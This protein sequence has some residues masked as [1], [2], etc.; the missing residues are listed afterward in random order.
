MTSISCAARTE[1]V[2][3]EVPLWHPAERALYWIDLFKP[4]IHRLDP[5]SGAVGSWT[6]P[7]KLG[8]LAFCRDGR[9]LLAGRDG[10]AK[11][12]TATGGM[13]LLGHP[14][15]D[16]PENI[17]NDGRADAVGRFWVGSMNKMLSGPTGRLFRVLPDR[18]WTVAAEDI[19]VPNS[20]AWSPDGRRMFFADSHRKLIW[21]WDF[22][23]GSGTLGERRLFADTSDMPGV[24]D[25][26]AVDVE[27][28][29]WN[30]RF[31]GG[32]VVRYDPDGRVERT[33]DLPVSR[34]S[35]CAFGGADLKTLYV[36]TA[37]FRLPPDRLAAEPLAGGLLA[38]EAGVAGLPEPCFGG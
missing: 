37:R 17:L 10:L 36:T 3:G 19:W 24:P 28:F 34:P 20:I 38:I 5:A 30:A 18:T 16:R 8:S 4:A 13:E 25:G 33:I 7:M 26:S 29:L 21:A 11:F 27:G 2:L 23:M 1:D 15:A 32:C 14:D 35:A 22:D 6:P 9:L 31:D 12:D